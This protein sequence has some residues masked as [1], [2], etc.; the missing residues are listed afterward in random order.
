MINGSLT[1]DRTAFKHD[2]TMYLIISV[3]IGI[4]GGL[5]NL[6]FELTARKL[7][8][9]LRIE[10]FRS[11]MAQDV[12]FFDGMNSGD[13][14]TRVNSNVSAMISPMTVSAPYAYFAPFPLLLFLRFV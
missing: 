9:S 1:G 5:R 4:F 11:L 13:L 3:T 7:Q 12:A 10:A 14:I 6:V 8:N 2:I